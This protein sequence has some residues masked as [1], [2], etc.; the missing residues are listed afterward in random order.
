[1]A[2]ANSFGP[3]VAA[4]TAAAAAIQSQRDLLAQYEAAGG[5]KDDLV[6]IQKLGHQAEAANL[7]QS[8]A[9][10][11]GKG[12]TEGVL[13][14]F[15]A[16]RGEYVAVMA[17]VQA[18]LGDLTRGGADAA[19]LST[20]KQ[21]LVN[22]VPVRVV[23]VGDG[24]AKKKKARKV[25]SLEAVRAEIA[26]DAAALLA[27]TGASAALAK[28]K[29]TAARLKALQ[30]DADALAGQVGEKTAK[31]GAAKAATAAEK[32]AVKAQSEV[33]AASY[34]ILS[35]V[36]RRDARIAALLKEAAA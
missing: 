17:A 25:E 21:V 18:V 12:A 2:K 8:V 16:L 26:K 10:G 5:L 6:A 20:L 15:D 24:D 14:A 35:A 4:R 13:E 28:R 30:A 9:A 7:G 36:G 31:K 3:V 34:R 32:A 23:E 1:M 11:T 22:E 27:A 19:L 33:W 29:V